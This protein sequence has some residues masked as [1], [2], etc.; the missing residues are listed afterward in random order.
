[1]KI[2]VK[3]EHYKNSTEYCDNEN[4]PLATA[5]KDVFSQKENTS[6]WVGGYTV[7]INGQRYD[8]GIEWSGLDTKEIESD[9]IK[10]KKGKEIPTIEVNLTKL[11]TS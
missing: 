6:I 2:Q 11:K 9:I 5:I 4:C 1:M 7:L 10:A 8:I 3:T